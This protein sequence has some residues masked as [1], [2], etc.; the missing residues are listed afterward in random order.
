MLQMKGNAVSVFLIYTYLLLP[1][2]V[3]QIDMLAWIMQSS[4]VHALGAL[5]FSFFVMI[6][7]N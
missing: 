1:V 3:P 7:V 4:F 5:N 2:T 6:L